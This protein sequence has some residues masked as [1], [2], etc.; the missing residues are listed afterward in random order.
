MTEAVV[1]EKKNETLNRESPITIG[2]MAVICCGVFYLGV[3]MTNVQRDISE[4]KRWQQESWTLLHQQLWL[5]SA[6][7]RHPE[8]E[9]PSVSDTAHTIERF[10]RTQ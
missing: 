4:L 3:T 8:I 2:L 5:E 7:K 6:R 1:T 10:R 9:W